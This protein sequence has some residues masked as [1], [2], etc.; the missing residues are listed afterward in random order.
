[1][2]R[3]FESWI[4]DEN[5]ELIKGVSTIKDF[6]LIMLRRDEAGQ[7]EVTS[8]A[9]QFTAYK[10]GCKRAKL[11]RDLLEDDDGK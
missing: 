5:R 7:Y 11:M 6:K 1:M 3:S 10:A 8:I 4:V 2:R 9:D